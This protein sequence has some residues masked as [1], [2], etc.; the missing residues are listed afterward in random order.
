MVSGGSSYAMQGDANGDA[1]MMDSPLCMERLRIDGA[2]KLNAATPS[3][4]LSCVD[5]DTCPVLDTP[6]SKSRVA[7][8]NW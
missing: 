5:M 8:P 3:R 1:M 2:S 4:N 6:K 7:A